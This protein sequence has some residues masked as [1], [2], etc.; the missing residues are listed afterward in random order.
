MYIDFLIEI[1][2]AGPVIVCPSLPTT[3]TD[4]QQWEAG[5]VGQAAGAFEGARPPS[6]HLLPDGTDAG[7]PG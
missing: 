5:S 4:P 7:Y 1:G 6:S 3:A 2:E